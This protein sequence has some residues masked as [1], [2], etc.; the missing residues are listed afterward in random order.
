MSQ[1]D[2][3]GIVT[4]VND[5]LAEQVHLKDYMDAGTLIVKHY[6]ELASK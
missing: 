2:N 6:T 1:G 3:N 5:S 4:F